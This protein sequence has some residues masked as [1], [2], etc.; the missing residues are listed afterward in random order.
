M[1]KTETTLGFGNRLKNLFVSCFPSVNFNVNVELK[2][3]F[4]AGIQTSVKNELN[5]LISDHELIC[6]R[7]LTFTEIIKLTVTKKV[8]NTNNNYNNKLKKLKNIPSSL[9]LNVISNP[10]PPDNLNIVSKFE[11]KIPINENYIISDPLVNINSN[12]KKN[13]KIK[14][15]VKNNKFGNT[16]GMRRSLS[17]NVHTIPVKEPVKQLEMCSSDLKS[18]IKKD[19][20]NL[21]INKRALNWNINMEQ[22]TF[23]PHKPSCTISTGNVSR[24]V[25]AHTLSYKEKDTEFIN[26]NLNK[27]LTALEIEE[28][29]KNYAINIIG[30]REGQPEIGESQYDNS[31]VTIA[32]T[33]FNISNN[34]VK[35]IDDNDK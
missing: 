14:N 22:V 28:K 18:C 19:N 13:K 2:N 20:N 33:E 35:Y 21:P 17:K 15:A 8:S 10:D 34:K 6:N 23:A 16:K 9:T 1:G 27:Q 12:K 30:G 26:N 4:M 7:N 3:K 29:R 25:P 24:T 5:E 11:N 32:F 31:E